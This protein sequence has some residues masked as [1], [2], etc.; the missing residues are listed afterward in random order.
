MPFGP[1]LSQ[2]QKKE[3]NDAAY[4]N[5]RQVPSM[6][7]PGQT[8]G[9]ASYSQQQK[10]DAINKGVSD[11][12]GAGRTPSTVIGPGGAGGF[13]MGSNNTVNTPQPAST[14]KPILPRIERK[15]GP[16][17]EGYVK[18]NTTMEP[19]Q[20][21]T[22]SQYLNPGPTQDT[23]TNGNG[24]V[25]DGLKMSGGVSAAF[26]PEYANSSFNQMLTTVNKG[27]FSSNQL[28]TTEGSPDSS[29]GPVTDGVAYGDMLQNAP[30]AGTKGIGPL[31]DGDAYAT[32]VGGKG[33]S[34][35]K[36]DIALNDKEGINS[37]M[38][39]FSSGDRQRAA[40]RAFLDT[41]G[42]MAGLRA[43]E[44]VQGKV[45]AGGQ[46]FVAGENADSPAVAISRDNARDISN[47]KAKAQDF[48]A[49]KTA[50]TVAAVKQSPA[51]LEEGAKNG[52]FQQDKPMFSGSTPA[53]GGA[54]E[55]DNNN[56][57]TLPSFGAPKGYK[58]QSTYKDPSFPNPFG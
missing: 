29:I 57:Q 6:M 9:D 26:V 31:A 54:V 43:K 58:P 5:N 18:P 3:I 47:G 49:K 14:Q 19:R 2:Q 23:R 48:L 36:L 7:T 52:A 56:S 42:S 35:S 53:I 38:S 13:G 33:K 28:P 25:Q 21:S 51:L 12:F 32:A 37:Y 8:Y 40:N 17:D 15:P 11:F 41:E 1:F 55:F 30:G 46:H 44:A 4:K 16:F 24:V 45:Y 50:D 39:Q 20:E 34:P 27:Q 22:L 10:T